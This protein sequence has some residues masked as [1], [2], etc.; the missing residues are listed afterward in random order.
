MYKGRMGGRI[1]RVIFK[2]LV[3]EKESKKWREIP[4]LA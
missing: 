2:K 1:Y 4:T 3:G